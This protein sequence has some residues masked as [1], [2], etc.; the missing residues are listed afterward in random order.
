MAEQKITAIIEAKDKASAQLKSFGGSLKAVGAIAAGAFAV[1]VGVKA[2]Q[3]AANFETAITNVSTLLDGDATDAMDQL[4]KG[5]LD[6]TKRVPKTAEDLGASAYDIFSAGVTD[7]ADALLVLENAG[8]LAVSGLGET[9]EATDV[10]TSA[11]NA[12]GI[13]ASESGQI[14]DTFFK[15]VKAGKT[16]ISELAQCFGQ[17]APLASQVGVGFE[18]LLSTTAAMTTSGLKASVAYTQVRS[19]LSSMLKP[20]KEMRD[21]M[22]NVGITSE[23]MSEIMDEKGLTGVVRMLS[24]SVDGNQAELA[25]MFGSVEALN[26]V[27]ML[28]GDTGETQIGIWENMTEGE[29]ALNA[30]T[31]KQNATF[32]NQ[33]ALLKN[34]WTKIMIEAG[35]VIIPALFKATELLTGAWN[36]AV[37]VLGTMI[38]KFMQL[39]E[40]AKKAAA[41]VKEAYSATV[42]KVG[43]L[44]GFANGGVVPGQLGAPTLA[45]VHGGERVIP[46]SGIRGAGGQGIVVN[47]SGNNINSELDI[48]SIADR[49]GREMIRTLGAVQNI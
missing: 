25:K 7:A 28:L 12:F 29:N 31:E 20:T 47:I 16:N 48:Q 22:E 21:A 44:L 8:K 38:F 23:N 27:M 2:V 36:K 11:I 40:W 39:V 5:I 24:Q 3:A 34:Q 9:K 26:A 45:V 1:N 17:V 4:S 6:M 10:M 43:G 35:N 13:D 46:P 32:N 33:V 15:A 49:V 42:G 41:A 19:A 37:D 18:D 30:A 14:A